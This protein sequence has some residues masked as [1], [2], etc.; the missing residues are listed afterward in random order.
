[1][2]TVMLIIYYRH[3]C[4]FLADIAPNRIAFE[5]SSMNVRTSMLYKADGS[6]AMLD[7]YIEVNVLEYV[8][9]YKLMS[10]EY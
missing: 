8:H 3:F 4:T 5:S 9:V 6:P 7:V 10:W 2:Q 1:M